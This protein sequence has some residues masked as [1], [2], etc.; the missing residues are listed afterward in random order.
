MI[1]LGELDDCDSDHDSILK[2]QFVIQLE[3]LSLT[4]FTQKYKKV[5]ISPNKYNN[6]LIFFFSF[7]HPYGKI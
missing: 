6:R 2:S 1:E 3:S 7:P 4:G 5:T